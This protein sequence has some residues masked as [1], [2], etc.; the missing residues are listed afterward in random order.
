MRTK[1][2]VFYSLPK[3]VSPESLNELLAH[4]SRFEE[5]VT[6]ESDALFVIIKL[7]KS[8]KSKSRQSQNS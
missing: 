3:D 6:P 5:Y 2:K 8:T 4:R 1:G 7:D